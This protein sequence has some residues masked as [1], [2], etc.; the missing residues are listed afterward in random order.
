M[1]SFFFLFFFFSGIHSLRVCEHVAFID[2]DQSNL[3]KSAYLNLNERP[4]NLTNL[5]RERT[6]LK[7]EAN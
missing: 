5:P 4:I 2:D 7:L 1:L 3:S 6:K